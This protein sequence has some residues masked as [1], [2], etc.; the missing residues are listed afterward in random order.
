M[1]HVRVIP[2]HKNV[3]I[4]TDTAYLG[5]GF[6]LMAIKDTIRNNLA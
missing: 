5:S 1:C 4:N 6:G 2:R 3:V